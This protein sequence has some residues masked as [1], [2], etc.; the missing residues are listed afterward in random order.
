[1]NR[2]NRDLKPNGFQIAKAINRIEGQMKFGYIDI[3]EDYDDI[4]MEVIRL[5]LQEFKKNHNLEEDNDGCEM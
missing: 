2:T 1:M 5:A 4:E 3:S